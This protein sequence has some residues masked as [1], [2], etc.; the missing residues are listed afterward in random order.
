MEER[1]VVADPVEDPQ[2]YQRELLTL[3][4]GADPVQVLAA[5]V[6]AA[7]ELTAGVP[8][9]LLEQRPEPAEWSAAEVIGHLWDAELVFSFR[10]RLIL[11]QDEPPLIGYDQ[12]AWARLARPGFG[13]LLDAY[14][15]LRVANLELVRRTPPTEWDRFGMHTERGRTSFR[16]L[17][18]TA[19]G[20]DR[21]HLRQLEQTLAAVR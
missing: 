14:A 4:G 2:G 13:A 20:H 3:L 12:D 18:E 10:A 5:T 17:T 8:A 15:A 9:P 7:R 11:A 1:I 6:P 16:L 19:A 21:A